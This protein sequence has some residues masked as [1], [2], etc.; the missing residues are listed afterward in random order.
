MEYTEIVAYLGT[1]VMS[2]GVIATFLKTGKVFKIVVEVVDALNQVLTSIKDGEL[3]K[4]E[5]QQIK[6]DIEDVI[7][8]IKSK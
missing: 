3:T 8:L 5:V 4:E 7:K 6:K 1:L 2:V